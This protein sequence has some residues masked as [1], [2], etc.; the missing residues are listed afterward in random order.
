MS[1]V[2]KKGVTLKKMKVMSSVK[3]VDCENCQ[4]LLVLTGRLPSVTVLPSG[5]MSM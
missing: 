5:I 2:P 3:R 1:L 4:K